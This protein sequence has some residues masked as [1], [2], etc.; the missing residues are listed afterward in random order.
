MKI[1]TSY[2]GIDI[3]KL[4]FDVAIANENGKMQHHKMSNDIK[5]FKQFSKLLSTN[6]HCCVMEASGPYYMKLSSFLYDKKIDVSVVNP[7]VIRRFSQMRMMRTKTDKKDAFMI[8]E[9]G[10]TE[11]PKLW[12]P[13][14]DYVL[15][16]KQIQAYIDQLTKNKTSLTNQSEAFEKVPVQSKLM[17]KSLLKMLRTLDKEMDVMNKRMEALVKKHHNKLFEQI[18]SVPGIGKKTAMELIVLSGGFTKFETAKQLSSY[19]GISP[20][21]FES[22]TSVRG[23][24]KICKMGMGRI[25]AM[26]YLCSWTARKCNKACR[27]LYDRLVEKGKPKK[28]ALIAVANKLLK[29]AFAI[30]TKNEFY[31][32]IS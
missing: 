18:K 1:N 12:K 8:A 16:L 20:R 32:E 4:T 22:G 3:S 5:G 24:V 25:R 15:E 13:D 30:G 27:E 17:N 31:M 29:Q 9:Y 21:I 2:V 7:L 14:A 10:K 11:V 6:N 23:K 26:L 19:V 28:V